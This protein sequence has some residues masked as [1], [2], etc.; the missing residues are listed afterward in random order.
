MAKA[1]RWDVNRAGNLVMRAVAEGRI[2]WAFRPPSSR[3]DGRTMGEGIWIPDT[4]EGETQGVQAGGD[5]LTAPN[6]DDEDEHEEEEKK[7]EEDSEIDDDEIARKVRFDF[8][9]IEQDEDEDESEEEGG[10]DWCG[11]EFA[12]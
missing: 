5:V 8:G 2:K 4:A 1:N 3:G 12:L 10:R 6:P 11:D 9:A 7:Q